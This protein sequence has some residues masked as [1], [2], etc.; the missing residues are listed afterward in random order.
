MTSLIPSTCNDFIL[1]PKWDDFRAYTF[2]FLI[3]E[4]WKQLDD[5]FYRIRNCNC[6]FFAISPLH[7][8][9]VKSDGKLDKPHY[10]GII[11]FANARYA[12]SFAREF[13]LTAKVEKTE[14]FRGSVRYLIHLD[15]PEKYP[16][17]FEDIYTNNIDIVAAMCRDVLTKENSDDADEIYFLEV[18]R[19]LIIRDVF[20]YELD[21]THWIFTHGYGRFFTK[22]KYQIHC[23]FAAVKA[24]NKIIKSKGEIVE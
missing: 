24:Q 16:Y 9:D 2:N 15:N 19:D 14:S 11:R 21:L 17:H 10:H 20:R 8:K 12:R 13:L 23:D 6:K 1:L 7:D 22:F 4:E 3:Y 18:V 5:V